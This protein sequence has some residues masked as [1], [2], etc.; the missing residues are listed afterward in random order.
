MN[1]PINREHECDMSLSTGKLLHAFIT[2]SVFI[3]THIKTYIVIYVT[4]ALFF[5]SPSGSFIFLFS[6]LCPP[7][8]SAQGRRLRKLLQGLGG[9]PRRIWK[10]NRRTLAW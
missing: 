7:G 5:S 9:V 8:F 1:P 10:D 2:G 3:I 6:Y 4:A